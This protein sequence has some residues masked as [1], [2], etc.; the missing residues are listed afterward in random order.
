MTTISL[1]P[2]IRP[3]P[4]VDT[5]PQHPA[6]TVA[7]A[8]IAKPRNPSYFSPVVRIDPKTEVAVWEVRDPQTGQVVQ[9]FPREATIKAYSAQSAAPVPA[10]KS[11]QPSART[12]HS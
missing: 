4:A 3:P 2:S 8:D 5:S 6:A 12:T 11:G 9:Q 10:E 7:S 1:K